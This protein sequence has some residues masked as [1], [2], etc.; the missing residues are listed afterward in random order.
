[1]ENLND[2]GESLNTEIVCT[3]AAL[4]CSEGND[5]YK[6]PDCLESLKDLIRFLRRDDTTC[7]IRRQLG[8]SE[9]LQNDLVAILKSCSSK[10]GEIFD[11][12]I[13]LMVNLTQPAVLCFGNNIPEDRTGQHYYL[14]LVTQLQSYKEAFT[15]KEVM[16]VIGRE[17]GRLLQMEWDDRLEEDSL[18]IERILLLIRNI[19]HVPANKQA[20]KRTDDDASIHD[21]VIWNL[22]TNGIDDLLL[23]IASSP[24]ERRWSMHILEIVTLMFREQNAES[25]AKAGQ[26]RSTS[27]KKDDNRQLEILR[28]QELANK[29]TKARKF[30]G[31]HS[32]FGGTFYVQN[33]KAIDDKNQLIYHR[34][35]PEVKNMSFDHNK[36]APKKRKKQ[37]PAKEMGEERRSTLSIRLFLKNFCLG[38]LE[39]C[40]NPLM[41]LVKDNLKHGRSQE[42]DETYFLWSM[43]FFME[44][45]RH[46]DF[47]VDY[48]S[49]TL[50]VVS[51]TDLL[52]IIIKFYDG[53]ES[54][55]AETL[56]WGRRL[57]LAIQAYKELLF[58]VMCMIKSDDAKLR[59]HAKIIQ[60]NIFYTAEYRDTFLLLLR[61]FHMTK[62][63]KSYLGDLIEAFHIFLKMLEIYCSGKTHIVVQKTKKVTRKKKR[64]PS[65]VAPVQLSAEETE[66]KWQDLA[67]DLSAWLQGNA[68]EIPESIVP[69]DA[70]SEIPVDEQKTN[71]LL[72]IQGFLRNQQ[73]A[74]AVA[75]LRAARDVWTEDELFGSA[76][77]SA[78]DEFMCLNEI[79]KMK[80]S[81][82]NMTNDF[83][84]EEGEEE[85]TIPEEEE[86]AAVQ[87]RETEFSIQEFLNKLAT[88]S[89]IQPYCWLLK[90]YK[91]NKDVTNHA[92]VKMLHRVAVDLKTP[93]MLFQLSLFGSFQKILSDPAASHYKEIVKFSRY[94]VAKFFEKLPKNPVLLAELVIWKTAKDCYE[95]EEGYGSLEFRSKSTNVAAWTFEEEEDLRQLYER[96]KG[97]DDLVDTIMENMSSDTKSRRQIMKKLVLM[98]LVTDRKELHKKA[99][100]KGTWT[101]EETEQLRALF[102]EYKSTEGDIV[103]KMMEHML[104]PSRTRR[105]VVNQLVNMG[106]VED[107]KMLRKKR[108][109][110]ERKKKNNNEDG[111]VVDDEIEDEDSEVENND[112]EEGFDDQSSSSDE[113]S[114]EDSDANGDTLSSIISKLQS[115]GLGDQLQWIQS[116]L[117]RIADD[118]EK[119]ENEKWQPLPLVT[120][121]EENEEA[122]SNKLFRKAMKKV[123]L[124]PPADEQETFWRI[125]V[126]LNPDRLRKAVEE[127][128][129]KSIGENVEGN[130]AELS[131]VK[132]KNKARKETLAALAAARKKNGSAST[133]KRK[134]R[135]ARRTRGKEWRKTVNESTAESDVGNQSDEESSV[136]GSD[137]KTVTPPP[138]GNLNGLVSRKESA[139]RKKRLVK[140]LDDSEDDDDEDQGT[141]APQQQG[142]INNN[143]HQADDNVSAPETDDANDR[144]NRG[145]SNIE[146][147][148]LEY[149]TNV[150]DAEET[151]KITEKRK[152]ETGKKRPRIESDDNDSDGDEEFDLPLIYHKKA[153]RVLV[154][155]DDDDDE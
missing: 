123:G 143:N 13:R 105:Q 35:L 44:F 4:G 29:L 69:F 19:L 77:M 49:E 41:Y 32:R 119:T 94:I 24:D 75:L 133:R 40:Y 36:T 141:S 89:V 135:S 103:E 124:K 88:P 112:R 144:T 79:F 126:S 20:E 22:H 34:P 106:I 152:S 81:P 155:D 9:V 115:E 93:S 63:T 98:K 8:Y 97:S 132:G 96:Y 61:K 121:T 138:S 131:P 114:E 78:E 150:S 100:K 37:L 55:K 137:V 74:D 85:D 101:E 6:S 59:D 51:F 117:R 68:G 50:S 107:R 71:A 140:A 111:F 147:D 90:F 33:M 1:M 52:N 26:G 57:H 5:Y 38:F 70:A 110:G 102:D 154:D 95:I 118:R 23:F 134:E 149:S 129:G 30:S 91:E 151:S 109:K 39:N 11:M 47:R 146:E 153:R 54:N 3:L 76:E 2:L 87:T 139:K 60:G 120:I 42:N 67:S 84:V 14:D 58:N 7:E 82:V 72:Q 99:V 17:L 65:T 92:I 127:L 18:L 104:N 86:M 145:R 113:E 46:H 56:V 73:S 128:D 116:K 48:I 66:Q 136:T 53:M 108:R 27:E 142:R 130:N 43:R 62:H 80:L 12:V 125:P 10:E 122:L 21:Q 25:L 16:S 45:S 15:E 28:Q 31:R 64:T 83:G 148:D